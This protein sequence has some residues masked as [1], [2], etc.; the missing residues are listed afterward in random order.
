VTAFALVAHEVARVVQ[1]QGGEPASR[2]L[3]GRVGR[4][5]RARGQS[6]SAAVVSGEP[7]RIGS[8]RRRSAILI[9]RLGESGVSAVASAVSDIAN[10]RSTSS[11]T[12]RG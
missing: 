2:L 7:A 11:G 1:Q 5:V 4:S 3:R 12:R 10:W 9:R 6:A 8:A